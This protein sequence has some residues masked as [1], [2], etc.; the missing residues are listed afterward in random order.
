M[1]AFTPGVNPK[2]SA[3]TINVFIGAY[4]LQDANKSYHGHEHQHAAVVSL[5]GTGVLDAQ[6][7]VPTRRK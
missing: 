3:L 2:S 4:N 7:D 1:P 6:K 5:Y